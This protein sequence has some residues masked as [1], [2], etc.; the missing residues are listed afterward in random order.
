MTMIHETH[1]TTGFSGS[2]VSRMGEFLKS[3]AGLAKSRI[4]LNELSQLD[5]HMLRD[6]G[7]NRGDIFEARKAPLSTDPVMLLLQASRAR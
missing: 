6:I 1:F 7:L 3:L 4:A 5:D 2:V